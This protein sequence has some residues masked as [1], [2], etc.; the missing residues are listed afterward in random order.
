MEIDGQGFARLVTAKPE[1][2]SVRDIR[3]ILAEN[4]LPIDPEE[5]PSQ[6]EQEQAVKNKLNNAFLGMAM[7][8]NS[9]G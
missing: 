9:G 8:D 4:G 3:K 5:Q 6:T 7:G 2:F 1:A